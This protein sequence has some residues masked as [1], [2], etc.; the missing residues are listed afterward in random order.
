MSTALI[1]QEAPVFGSDSV[2]FASTKSGSFLVAAVCLFAFGLLMLFAQPK[3]VAGAVAA[4]GV[5]ASVAFLI[6]GNLTTEAI[7]SA[8]EKK[9]KLTRRLFKWR[10]LERVCAYNEVRITVAGTC[11]PVSSY[12]P[13][14]SNS[15]AVGPASQ[16]FVL[17]VQSSAYVL[18]FGHLFTRSE[19]CLPEVR[20]VLGFSPEGPA[21]AAMS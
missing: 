10:L 21:K 17:R 6:A 18:D 4:G 15:T 20:R 16:T 8:K 11:A 19:G 7:F 13:V 3:A 9:I 1:L 5:G 12:Y 14:L 2:S